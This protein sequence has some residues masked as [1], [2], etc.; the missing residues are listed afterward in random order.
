MKN[1]PST[2]AK[3]APGDAVPPKGTFDHK[4]IAVYPDFADVGDAFLLLNKNGF[5]N[6][7]ISVLGREQPHWQENVGREWET[8]KVTKAAAGG[9][10]L[11]AVPGLVLLSGIVLTGGVGVLVV[12]PM[13]SA[14]ATLGMG[15]LGGGV[16]GAG[17]SLLDISDT[18]LSVEQEV[19]E[20]I[21]LGQWV[22]VVH[23]GTEAEAQRAR[24]L[25]PYRRIARH[26][27]SIPMATVLR[28]EEQIDL[29]K[30]GRIVDEA[31]ELVA[32]ESTLPALEVMCNLD[33]HEVAAL[34]QATD[35]AITK[36]SFATDLDTAQITEIFKA[37]RAAGMAVIV[38]RLREQSISHRAP[39]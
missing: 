3:S 9:A 10:A 38:D 28:A 5:S 1:A 35:A 16:M 7:Q 15:A 23:T 29:S 22:V 24:A 31:F 39:W 12:G 33:G 2:S 32:K 34:K 20:A 27:D 17:S 8:F 37:N 21:G 4:T 36:I 26:E 18:R 14:M 11:G 6:D 13:V 25:M 19:A 30:L